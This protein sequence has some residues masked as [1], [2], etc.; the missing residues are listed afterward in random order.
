MSSEAKQMITDSVFVSEPRRLEETWATVVGRPSSA[1]GGEAP[2]H[3]FVALLAAHG[4]DG[5]CWHPPCTKAAKCLSEEL[6]GHSAKIVEVAVSREE[7][8]RKDSILRKSP[9]ARLEDLPQLNKFVRSSSDS[10][11]G[12]VGGSGGMMASIMG[13]SGARGGGEESGLRGYELES[14]LVGDKVCDKDAVRD[15]IFGR[16]GGAGGST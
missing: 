8:D 1:G 3:I 12:R 9:Y 7:F 15:F 6:S 11:A 5:T 10:S 16:S 13:G 2:R 14:K 4:R